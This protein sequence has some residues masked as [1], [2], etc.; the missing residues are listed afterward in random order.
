MI[1]FEFYETIE[2]QEF[3]EACDKYEIQEIIEFLINENYITPSMEI[4]KKGYI[5]DIEWKETINKLSKAR[6][7]MTREEEEIIKT[8]VN[9]K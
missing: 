8:I 2:V 9:K 6:L 1:S 7:K 5:P 4:E 3:L